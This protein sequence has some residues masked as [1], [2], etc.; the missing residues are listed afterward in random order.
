MKIFVSHSSSYDYVNKLYKPLQKS[1]INKDHKIFLLHEDRKDVLTKD[2]IKKS[3][4]IVAEVSFPSTGQGIELGWANL[5]NI[6]I[7]CCYQY[8]SKPSGSLKYLAKDFIIY[9]N[10]DQMIEKLA[11]ALEKLNNFSDRSS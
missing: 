11:I 4:V 10:K 7:I 9:K 5:Y 8:A 6:P 1:Q 2:I 3:D